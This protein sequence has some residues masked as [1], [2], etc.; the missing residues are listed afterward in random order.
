M[1]VTRLT[2]PMIK[3]SG[4]WMS[5]IILLAGIVMLG[6]GVYFGFVQT[7]GYE[8]TK[9]TVI[10]V[11]EEESVDG[12]G[13]RST[14]YI[15]TVRYAVN[16]VEYTVT[17]KDGMAKNKQDQEISI[18][19][20]PADPEKAVLDTPGFTVYLIGV[21]AVLVAV[22]IYSFLK[23][24][25]QREQLGEQRPLFGSSI[26]GEERRL[27]FVT[28]LGTA[29][30]TCHIEDE[31][32]TVLYEA[33]STKFSVLADSEYEFVDHVLNRR[34]SHL[35]GKT[36]TA[37]SDAIW[38]LDSHSTFTLDGKDVWKQL[39]ENGVR[40]ETELKGL[41]FAYTIFRDGAEIARAETANKLVH[42]EDA[43]AAGIA[44]KAP[45]PG[46]FR[47]RTGEQNLDVVFLVLFAIGRTD[48]I[49]YS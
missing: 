44:A 16:G 41:H 11:R 25:K 18:K 34:T 35:V 30:G 9:A 15:P 4:K 45:V 32:R 22:E 21:G 1:N 10:R 36:A 7:Q 2:K 19:Y 12:E 37:A 28:D 42:E 8:K 49:S 5:V 39:H 40:I 13:T 6:C 46:F 14:S 27:Y 48:M 23:K 33:V 29:K 43:E 3:A 24:R 20:D 26:R 17:L 47:I 38:V 31:K